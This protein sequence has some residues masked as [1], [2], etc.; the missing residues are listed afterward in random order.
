MIDS[1][2]YA[3]AQ[4]DIDEGQRLIL[5]LAKRGFDPRRIARVLVA[6][7]VHMT[8]VDGSIPMEE[9]A[10]WFHAAILDLDAHLSRE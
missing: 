8:R 3:E 9:A 4:A 1:K 5:N 10:S 7:I 6:S 2:E